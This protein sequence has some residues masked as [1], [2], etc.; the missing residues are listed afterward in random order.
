MPMDGQESEEEGRE[1][2]VKEVAVLLSGNLAMRR[3]MVKYCNR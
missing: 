1:S 3:D 2:V